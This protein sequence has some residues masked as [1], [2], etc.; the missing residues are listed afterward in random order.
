M[1]HRTELLKR[2]VF[3]IYDVDNDGFV[4]QDDLYYIFKFVT[5]SNISDSQLEVMVDIAFSKLDDS[6]DRKVNMA[7][8]ADFMG[9]DSAHE[10][11]EID[12]S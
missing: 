8:F 2:L 5:C 7:E 1:A 12:F 11:L 9:D 4:G 10:F 3:R 6:G